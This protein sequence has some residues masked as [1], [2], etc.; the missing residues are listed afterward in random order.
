M[1][2]IAIADVTLSYDSSGEARVNLGNLAT[3]QGFSSNTT[4]WGSEG[5]IGVP[6]APAS[7]N[8]AA[9]MAL[10]WTSGQT[11]YA[12]APRDDR[13]R[14]QAGVMAV[15][16]RAVTSNCDAALLLQQA[17]NKIQ[18]LALTQG[19]EI[20]LDA[21]GETTFMRTALGEVSLGPAGISASWTPAA[22]ISASLNLSTAGALLSFTLS[23]LT[24]SVGL[25][26]GGGI[27]FTTIPGAL[28]SPTGIVVNGVALIVP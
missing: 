15:G 26:P 13:W 9:C 4:I 16:D 24:C 18:L 5:F 20:T 2:D 21:A 12:F 14:E 11:R 22:G 28:F 6:N 25:L 27:S 7:D 23:G 10:L 8:T 19:M 1:A 17:T 3:G